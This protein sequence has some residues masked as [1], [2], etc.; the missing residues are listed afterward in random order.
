MADQMVNI[1]GSYGK[2]AFGRFMDTIPMECWHVMR[3]FLPKLR[4][5]LGAITDEELEDS[6]IEHRTLVEKVNHL[7]TQITEFEAGLQILEHL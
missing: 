2:I 6:M 5:S 7:K 4:K 1:L 3:N